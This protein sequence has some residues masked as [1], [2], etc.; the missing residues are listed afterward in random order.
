MHVNLDTVWKYRVPA[1]L[2]AVKSGWI[3]LCALGM[4]AHWLSV[5]TTRGES[6]TVVTRRMPPVDAVRTQRIVAPIIYAR[7]RFFIDSLKF[8]EQSALCGFFK[9]FYAARCD[10]QHAQELQ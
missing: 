7:V 1:A 9:R 3:M 4:R 5:N 10:P 6:T 2:A 8:Y